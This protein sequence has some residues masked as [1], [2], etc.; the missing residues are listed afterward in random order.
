MDNKNNI[1]SNKKFCFACGQQ[2]LKDAQICPKCG[3]GQMQISVLGASENKSLIGTILL[4]Y[5]LGSI[6]VHYFYL[7]KV[8]KG[9]LYLIFS[10]TSIPYIL[11][12]ISLIGLTTSNI[13]KLNAKYSVKFTDCEKGLKILFLILTIATIIGLLY[14]LFHIIVFVVW[15]ATHSNEF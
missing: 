4:T 12:C 3:V 9:V 13:E 6:G 11:S 2:I 7:G 14:L 10:W 1:E 5:F 8:L 15:F